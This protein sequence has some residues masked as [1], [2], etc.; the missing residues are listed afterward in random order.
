M[1]SEGDAKRWK[2]VD[3]KLLSLHSNTK[4]LQWYSQ[5]RL[6]RE[7]AASPEGLGKGP[8]SEFND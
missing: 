4:E 8:K 2:E 7:Y 5:R 1:I 3:E 6:T